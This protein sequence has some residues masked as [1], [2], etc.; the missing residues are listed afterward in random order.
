MGRYEAS[1]DGTYPG[2][3]KDA[4]GSSQVG[5]VSQG[6]SAL[7][8]HMREAVP[9]CRFLKKRL[10]GTPLDM[11]PVPLEQGGSRLCGQDTQCRD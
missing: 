2:R 10:R 7:F 4:A 6:R 1:P 5:I 9:M 3:W 8:S 11:G